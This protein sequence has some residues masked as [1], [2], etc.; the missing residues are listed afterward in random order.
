MSSLLLELAFTRLFSVILFYHFAFMVISIALLGLGAGGVFAF[1]HKEWLSRI[2]ICTLAGWLC[3]VNALLIVIVMEIDLYSPLTLNLTVN[4]LISALP[5]FLV[6]LLFSVLF[7]RQPERITSLYGADLIGGATACIALVPL[8][9]WIGAPNTV[10]GAAVLMGLAAFFWAGKSRL[11]YV[12]VATAALLALLVG[13]NLNNQLIDIVSAKG[14]RRSKAEVLWARWNAI[15]RVEVDQEGDGRYIRIDSDAAT[16]IMNVDP[17]RWDVDLPRG[18]AEKL[19]WRNLVPSEQ[20]GTTYNWKRDLMSAAPAM[21]NVLRPHGDYAVIGPGG[22]VDVMRAVANGATSVTAIEINPLIANTI[23]R[24]T[25]A[26]YSYHLYERPNVHLHVADGRSWIRASKDKY[27]VIQM[28]LVDTWASTAAGAFAL[29]E[30]NLYTVEAFKEYFDHLKPDGIIAITRWEFKEPREALRVVSVELETM[31]QLGIESDNRFI[32]ISDGALD[33]DGRPVTVLVKKTAFTDAEIESAASHLNETKNL[34]EIFMPCG[35]VPSG[36]VNL[37]HDV[38]PSRGVPGVTLA[39]SGAFYRL[40]LDRKR[41]SFIRDYE[42]DIS[43][44]T[45]DAPFFFFTIKTGEVL[46]RFWAGTG[47]GVDWRVNM[48]SMTLGLVLV[49]SLVTVFAFLVL[50]MMFRSNVRRAASVTKLLY[51]VAVGL[52]FILVEVSFIQR[53]VL[54]LGHPTY[55]LTVVVFLLLLSSGVGS[56]FSRRWMASADR[57]PWVLASIAACIAML[58]MVLPRLLE[59]QVGQPFPL[60]VGIAG[61]FLIPLGLAMGMPFPT[62]L[63][64]LANSNMV[65]WAWAMNAAATVLGSVSAIVIAIHFGLTLTLLCGAL[66]YL[67]AAALTPRL[68]TV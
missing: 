41:D 30:N 24:G 16:A 4:Y 37:C 28:T 54:F 12:G 60:K 18:R 6:G 50:P 51:F 52:G 19:A 13:L 46:K 20:S 43:P 47:R 31:R 44:S 64:M 40:L 3:V 32:V 61:A 57:I 48:G 42:Y 62:G 26:D 36:G 23:M 56:L 11:G 14:V 25:H 35:A 34:K 59:S 2:E 63:R 53:F 49:V 58:A 65:E 10:L 21:V 39:S 45:D 15:S 9:N 68:V 55:A 27:D 8:L 29:S 22:G 67:I 66:A 7:A 5:F 17:A 1:L 38:A 33:T